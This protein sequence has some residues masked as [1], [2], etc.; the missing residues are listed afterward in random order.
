MQQQNVRTWA[1]ALFTSLPDGSSLIEDEAEARFI[2]FRPDGSV[3]AE[4]VNRAKDGWM[5]K[6]GWSRYINKADGDAIL[7]NLRK[8]KCNA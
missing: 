4:F 6:L 7:R 2:L 5:Y 1:G 3:G 8:V